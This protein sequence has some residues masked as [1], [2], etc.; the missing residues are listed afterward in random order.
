MAP[1]ANS[2][3]WMVI[4]I[5]YCQLSVVNCFADAVGTWKIYPSYSTITKAEPTGSKVYALADGNLYSYNLTSTEVREYNITTNPALN[6]RSITNM[7]WVK[8]AGKLLI[9]YSDYLIDL[10]S[11]KDEVTSIVGLR[12]ASSL[13]DK[14][15]KE[16]RTG[17]KYAY[18]ITGLG[19]VKID[20]KDDYIVG[21]YSTA[22]EVPDMPSSS[23]AIATKDG[24]YGTVWQDISNKCWWGGDADGGLTKYTEQDDG[25]LVAVSI[26]VRPDGPLYKEH[27]YIKFHQGKLYSVRGM[28]ERFADT[29]TPGFLQIYDANSDT[30]SVADNS[31]M[32]GRGKNIIA[33]T[34]IDVDPKDA[35]HVMVGAKSGL[36]EFRNNKLVAFYDCESGTPIKSSLDST[37][38]AQSRRNY[39]VISGIKFDSSGNLWIFNQD[40]DIMI[41]LTANGEWKSLNLVGTDKVTRFKNPFFDSRGLLWFADEFWI[42]SRYGF[43]DTRSNNFRI[44]TS[45]INQDGSRIKD[46][47]IYCKGVAEDKEGNIWYA[48]NGGV[49]YLSPTEIQYMI[50]NT[51]LTSMHINQYKVNRNDGS[52]LADY[53]LSSVEA[54]D[55]LIDNLNQKWVA[56]SQDGLYYISSD[57]NTEIHHFTT[58]N[59]PL[60]TDE[61]KK[62]TFDEETGILYIGTDIGLC[63]YQTD[64]TSTSGD[65]SD[66]NVY[67]YPNPV[68][69]GYTGPIT[70][71]GLQDG[72]IITITNTSGFVVNKG[73]CTGGSYTWNGCDRGGLRVASGVY[74]VL[75]ATN[76]GESGCVTKIAVVR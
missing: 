12:D 8:G 25:T 58:S 11:S 73:T 43:Y 9:V 74:N 20:A 54:T 35:N 63:S 27:N 26:G 32:E 5:V 46:G 4:V 57:N 31:E 51:D 59:S 47:S 19:I 28:Y 64:V 30:W 38:S 71:T 68:E 41:C 42:P 45:F 52:G 56:T 44:S 7:V 70:I 21:T 40:S 13:K 10:L 34:C 6:G 14:T 50:N 37:H 55:I 3:I 72:C 48:L 39:T 66:D 76:E 17:G 60:P 1:F 16:I 65:L 61:I 29:S 36:Y 23:T 49:M 67:A 62:L 75:V 2:L 24:P 18:L 22:E 69:P 15:I 33:F 53:L